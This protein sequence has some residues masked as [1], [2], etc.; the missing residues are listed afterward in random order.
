MTLK[1]EI[2]PASHI[3]F[4]WKEGASDL[5]ISCE[6]SGGE[7]TG[8]QLKLLLSRGE[9]ILLRAV[10]GDRVVGWSVVK[11]EQLPNMR[12]LFVGGIVG[13]NSRYERFFDALKKMALVHGC[14]RIRCAA[15]P[16][17]ARMNRMKCGFSSVYEIMEVE[18]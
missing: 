16:A 18:L 4:A 17:Q 15:K 14:S 9:R 1:L 11:V 10:D 3:D 13:R 6:T 2:I 12:V 5:A 7:I 8:D